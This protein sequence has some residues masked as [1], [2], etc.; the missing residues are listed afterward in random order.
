MRLYV[1]L[2]T[3]LVW[4]IILLLTL[5]PIVVDGDSFVQWNCYL[6]VSEINSYAIFSNKMEDIFGSFLNCV[7]GGTTF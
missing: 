2:D 6:W 4:T 5:S 7:A 1:K 3:P